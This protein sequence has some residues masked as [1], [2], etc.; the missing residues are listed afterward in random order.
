MPAGC[1]DRTDLVRRLVRSVTLAVELVGAPAPVPEPFP[2]GAASAPPTTSLDD[3]ARTT[4]LSPATKVVEEAAMLL[5]AAAQV[6][7]A[8]PAVA[9]AVERL[10]TVLLP[11]RRTE[12]VVAALLLDPVR[13]RDHTCVHAVL[14][15]LGHPDPTLDAL[16]RASVQDG[17]AS[18]PERLPY[19]ELEQHWLAR[20]WPADCPDR[21]D[22]DLVR[23]SCLGR[24]VDPLSATPADAYALTHAVLYAADFG[25][26]AVRLPRPVGELAADVEA[27]LAAC[28]D[29]D[30]LDL[31]A[32]LLWT[33]PVLDL[34]WSPAATFAFT[35]LA[36]GTG[37]D[38]L[39]PGPDYD[40][41]VHTALGTDPRAGAYRHATCYHTTF[42]TGFLCAA[43]L[44]PG[45]RPPAQ[46]AA[47]PQSG[48]A[49]E[50]V[51]LLERAGPK[52]PRWQ[53]AW[54]ALPVSSQDAVSGFVLAA[55]LCRARNAGDLELV[56]ACLRVA[57]AADLLTAPAPRH[58]L[59]LLRRAA[60]YAPGSSAPVPRW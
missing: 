48:A 12:T 5:F 1:W 27:L 25:S 52:V 58:A 21:D 38:G 44:R 50:L 60:V 39:T 11:H 47:V 40:D 43:A 54:H 42:V 30:D 35:V 10:T 51:A 26:R 41:A 13:A 55:A 16:L 29:H 14:S 9:S 17:A 49:A 59:T 31:A 20:V 28:L 24:A 45:R 46:V 33:W 4:P 53:A 3:T 18:A 37:P 22:S 57:H 6:R 23:S 56:R 7:D 8:D 15:R 19:R 36:A 34:S 2:A 32:E